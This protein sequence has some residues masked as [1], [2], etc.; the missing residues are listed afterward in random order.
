MTTRP[1]ALV[2]AAIAAVVVAG[3]SIT[4]IVS[5]VPA[6][7]VR[8]DAARAASDVD[9]GRRGG[10]AVAAVATDL[11]RKLAA[12]PGNVVFSP[13]SVAVTLAMTRAG[14]AG[15]TADEIDAV[16]H[17]KLAGD[18]DAAF[19]ALD[20]ALAKRPGRYPV[21]QESV[22]LA[23]ATAD[24]LW[25]Q[26]GF[27]FEKDFLDRLAAYYGAGMRL[28]D[29]VGA[30]EQAR[31]EINKWVADRTHDRIPKLIP[32][33]VLDEMTRLVLTNAIYLKAPWALPFAKAR[34]AAAPFHRLDGS[35]ASV[36][37]MSLSSPS[38]AY[39]S[40]T[41]YQAVQLRYVG[42]L[43]MVV[44]VP[45]AGTLGGFEGTLGDAAR[46][47]GILAALKGGQLVNL[48]LPRF[49]FRSQSMLKKPLGDLGMPTAFSDGADF[50]RM[51]A[52]GKELTIQDVVHEAFISVDEEGTEA[53][54]AT[55]AVFGL[56]S[57]PSR[58]VDVTVDRP[59]L[60]LIR[61]D[62]TGAILF[63]GRVVDP[64]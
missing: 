25:A 23:L 49:S 40:D 13:Y 55:A 48:R 54:A 52:R 3:C 46:L 32:Q 5:S 26:T 4:E 6:A 35:T 18:L 51:S 39:A 20:Q 19:N 7:V 15:R 44:V 60:F 17:A 58:V 2:A 28:V 59:F 42:G 64:S 12:T 16:L 27:P 34:T 8:S 43:S 62:E 41:G 38:L 57:A 56:T 45:D 22:E 1:S 10:A 63:M 11:Y 37:F 33:G 47:P 21:G 14:A 36:P 30:R 29:Y 9:S 31:A 61:D 50:S 24:Q 53:A